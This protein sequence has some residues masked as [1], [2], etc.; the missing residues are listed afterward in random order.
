MPLGPSPLVNKQGPMGSVMPFQSRFSGTDVLSIILFISERQSGK[1]KEYLRT[2]TYTL[3]TLLPPHWD[4]RS[5]CRL[6]FGCLETHEGA[7][8][9]PFLMLNE[10]QLH[11]IN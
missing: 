8:D 6:L 10:V 9:C 1:K 7:A 2:Y 5:S 4:K 11:L 3:P